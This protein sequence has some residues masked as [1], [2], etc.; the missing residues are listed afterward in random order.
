MLTPK[1]RLFIAEYLKDKNG[2]RAAIAAGYKKAGAAVTASK[3]IRK[4]NVAEAINASLT[5]I[6][7]KAELTAAEVL[8]EIRKLAFADVTDA[9]DENGELKN[10]KTL[11]EDVRKALSS[12]E[13]DE[14]FEGFGKE[15]EKIGV[16]RKVKFADKVRALEM[17]AKYFK[18]LTDV[19][20]V[21]G[22]NGGPQVILTMP[23]NGSE[24]KE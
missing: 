16:T 15:R 11:P 22:A 3:L 18:L 9:F 12:V 20:E 17:L 4:P 13:T 2:S 7:E 8:A 23:A 14:L 5:Q 6:I 24:A 19:S 1:E 10:L 21:T